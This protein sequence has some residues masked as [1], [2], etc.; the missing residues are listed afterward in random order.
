MSKNT[1]I[2]SSSS[3]CSCGGQLVQWPGFERVNPATMRPAFTFL[4]TRMVSSRVVVSA[5]V[6]NFSVGSFSTSM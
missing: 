4:P 2:S 5:P 1:Y 3:A 6:V